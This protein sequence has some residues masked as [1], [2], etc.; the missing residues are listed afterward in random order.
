ML[1]SLS[2][3]K[4]CVQCFITLGAVSQNA[5]LYPS[6]WYTSTRQI[7]DCDVLVRL[8]SMRSRTWIRC[9]MTLLEKVRIQW[10]SD[11][12]RKRNY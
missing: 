10:T 4:K 8:V 12:L 2:L 5:Q 7:V 6:C 1:E 9:R 11:S 3:V